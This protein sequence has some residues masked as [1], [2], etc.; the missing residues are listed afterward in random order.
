MIS[1]ETIAKLFSF[2]PK[3]KYCIEIEFSVKGHPNYQFC[4]MGKCPDRDHNDKA[5]YWYGLA[6]DGSEAYNYAGFAEFSS[7]AV[8]NSRSL[9]EIWDKIEILSI[10]GSDPEDQLPRYLV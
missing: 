3:G 1:F 5:T 6:P 7:A 9:E 8:F 2:D 10:D 4:W